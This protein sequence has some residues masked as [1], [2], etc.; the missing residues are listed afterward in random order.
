[1][2]GATELEFE[3]RR[4]GVELAYG[5]YMRAFRGPMGEPEIERLKDEYNRRRSAYEQITP[6]P[7]C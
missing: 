1:M 6:E 7:W 3:D 4:Y 5:R 2:R